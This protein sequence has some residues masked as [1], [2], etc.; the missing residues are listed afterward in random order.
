[1]GLE[2]FL[3]LDDVKE[4]M[5]FKNKYEKIYTLKK[6]HLIKLFD[7]QV[8]LFK[9]S[10][11]MD[12]VQVAVKNKKAG[13]APDLPCVMHVY[14]FDGMAKLRD[15]IVAAI[16]NIDM[17]REWDANI[18]QLEQ[19]GYIHNQN[20]VM[21]RQVTQPLVEGYTEREIVMKR[22]IF[23]KS[24]KVYVYFSSCPDTAYE[25][26]AEEQDEEVTRYTQVFG[27][28]CFEKVRNVCSVTHLQQID[29]RAKQGVTIAAAFGS[30]ETQLERATAWYEN[31]VSYLEGGKSALEKK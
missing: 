11:S 18:Q 13:L 29:F 10:S 1:L 6:T 28:W 31:L 19:V 12:P 17:R 3:D 26:P 24:D 16:C 14:N 23:R 27:M 30:E 8:G 9:F 20:M 21:W 22:F 2:N 4:S 15:Q 5:V 25:T 7:K